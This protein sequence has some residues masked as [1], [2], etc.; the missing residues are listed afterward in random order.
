LTFGVATSAGN[1]QLVA[2]DIV[3]TPSG[4]FTKVYNGGPINP[5]KTIVIGKAPVFRAGAL[6]ITF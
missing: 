5:A 2:F 6:V 3:D 4:A 1:G